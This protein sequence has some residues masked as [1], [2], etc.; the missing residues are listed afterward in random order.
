VHFF[1]FHSLILQLLI[2][3]EYLPLI[4]IHLRVVLKR[5]RIFPSFSFLLA[6]VC[7]NASSRLFVDPQE[8]AA[9]RISSGGNAEQIS[10]Q[11]II[12]IRDPI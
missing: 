12:I 2:G 1:E 11:N 4:M 3:A 8:E 6:G 9:R 10:S 5:Y 7:S